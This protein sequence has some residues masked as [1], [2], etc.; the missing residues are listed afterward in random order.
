MKKCRWPNKHTDEAVNQQDFLYYADGNINF[1][2]T[3]V[4]NLTSSSIV[5]DAQTLRLRQ[6][7][8]QI[9]YS[10]K[11]ILECVNRRQDWGYLQQINRSDG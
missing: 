8:C 5:E 9:L 3:L 2:N 7:C 10:S 4:G 6:F 11:E 1:P